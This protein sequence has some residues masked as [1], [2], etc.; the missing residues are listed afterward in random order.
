[1]NSN[2]NK[3]AVSV[4]ISVYNREE[5]LKMCIDSCLNQSFQDFKIIIVN[6]GS[7][8]NSKKVI[9]EYVE[10]FP[11]KIHFIDKENG[12]VST[13]RNVAFDVV[14]SKYIT[15]LDADDYFEKDYLEQ[16]INK[17]EKGDFDVVVS[18]QN[19][20][21]MEGKVLDT[22]SYKLTDGKTAQ[23]R[24]NIAGKLYKFEYIRKWNITFPEGKYYEDNSFNLQAQ[25]LSPKVGFMEYI[26]YN[27]V[28]HE[29][30]IT[31]SPIVAARLPFDEWDM[32][33][34]KIKSKKVEGVDIDLFD[35]TFVSFL[36]YFLLVRNRKREYLSNDS[37]LNSRDS[38]MQITNFFELLIN[39]YFVGYNKN[40]YLNL[41]KNKELPLSQKIGTY[42]FYR[43]CRMKKLGLVVNIAFKVL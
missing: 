15:F 34:E 7:V 3:T 37:E 6:D 16:V 41:F 20:V 42:V 29:G 5:Y 26:G 10:R 39:K 23:R 40:P 14:N 36:T 13:A 21:T 8:D 27:Q 38:I 35:F 30:S 25:F 24:L 11:E 32:L 12:G 22:I 1:M 31:A 33:C 43:A 9:E 28:V 18:G 19:K 2:L 17:A 4:I